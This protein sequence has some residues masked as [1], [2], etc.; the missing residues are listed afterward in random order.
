MKERIFIDKNGEELIVKSRKYAI[1]FERKVNVEKENSFG[2][3]HEKYICKSEIRGLY[4]FSQEEFEKFI[5]YCEIIGK[6]TWEN[7]KFKEAN[8]Y[9]VAY[10]EYYDKEFD[11][12]GFLYVRAGILSIEGPYTQLKSNGEMVRLFKFNKPKFESFIFELKRIINKESVI[13]ER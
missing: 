5:S 7:F 1:Y 13:Y 10:N 4:N 8:S 2:K 6:E 9:N 3:D 12:E 11:N